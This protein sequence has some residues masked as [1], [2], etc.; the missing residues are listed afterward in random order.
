MTNNKKI[1]IAYDG[2]THTH[3]NVNIPFFNMPAYCARDNNSFSHPTFTTFICDLI[4][5]IL[6]LC[7]R[8][9]A[10]YCQHK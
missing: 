4:D 6:H 8:Q 3:T 10:I 2:K 9:T 5:V 7:M 1:I